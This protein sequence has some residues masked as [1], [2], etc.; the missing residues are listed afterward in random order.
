[1]SAETDEITLL[2]ERSIFDPTSVEDVPSLVERAI[3][4]RDVEILELTAA[5]L[6]AMPRVAYLDSLWALVTDTGAAIDSRVAALTCVASIL[7]MSM[8]ELE[9]G[10]DGW[11][12]DEDEEPL[13]DGAALDVQIR[14]LLDMYR[15]VDTPRDLRRRALEAAANLTDDER[16]RS[17]GL[18]A[19]ASKE[20]EWIVTGLLVA[21]LVDGGRARKHLESALDH[22]SL[23]VRLEAIR[24]LADFGERRD[25][26]T[27][28]DICV[29]GNRDERATAF[30]ALS[31][32]PRQEAGDIL[33][34][35]TESLDG[36]D[37]E[38]AVEA[39]ELWMEEFGGL[40]DATL[41]QLA[42]MLEDE[43]PET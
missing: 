6:A 35:A 28:G 19:L 10:A 42:E 7:L 18:A 23:E 39:Y 20:P 29:K 41:A 17:A 40:D 11:Q 37:L 27:L 36:D 30:L 5:L 26:E 25:I 1:M 24:G 9:A 4:T 34:A 15:D 21:R 13:L 43:E 14:R 3:A 12:G 31:E 22:A 33:R 38:D 32:V 16:V 2:L 8:E